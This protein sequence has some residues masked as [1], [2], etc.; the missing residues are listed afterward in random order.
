MDELTLIKR[1]TVLIMARETYFSDFKSPLLP[2]AS[3]L[4][5]VSCL[6]DLGDGSVRDV[7]L[8]HHAVSVSCYHRP[9]EN[10]L[11]GEQRLG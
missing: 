9:S 11:P 6:T 8:R 1:L 7:G 2:G 4:A 5:A 10:R 3:H